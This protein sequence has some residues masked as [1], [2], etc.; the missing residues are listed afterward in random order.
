MNRVFSET[1]M[2]LFYGELWTT[3]IDC[4]LLPD[5]GGVVARVPDCAGPHLD[6]AIM[7]ARK[8]YIPHVW[9]E[10]KF[11]VEHREFVYTFPR[12]T[13]RQRLFE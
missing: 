3:M 2:D 6:E 1:A 8:A 12:R 9:P 5:D 7:R 11:D 13:A 4:E 10:I